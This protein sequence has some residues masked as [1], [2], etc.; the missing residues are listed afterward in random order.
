VV[1]DGPRRRFALMATE[2][3][4]VRRQPTR[5]RY[6]AASV[7]AVLDAGLFA[8]V[9]FVDDGQPYCI[10]MLHARVG[11]AV[12]V[13]GSAASRALRVL[14]GGVPACLTVTLLDGLV[15]ARSVFEHSANYR[16]AVVLGSFRRVDGADERL[17][18]L[19]AFTEKL[20]PGRWQ[21]VRGP[22][23]RE[24]RATW[25]LALGLDEA[26][27]KERTGPPSDGDGPDATLDVW[28]GV[29]PVRAELGPPEPAPELARNT[30]LAPSVRRLLER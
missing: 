7:H 30:E 12:Y 6:D 23:E 22:N 17:A 24:L 1:D 15:L 25:I 10:P 20:V 3:T 8:H 4:R 29:V 27:V 13:H 21:E 2:R 9:A 5:G 16:A 26:S 14:A 11:D 28:A 19:E 18:A